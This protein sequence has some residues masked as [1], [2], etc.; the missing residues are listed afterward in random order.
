MNSNVTKLL[1]EQYSSLSTE[2]KSVFMR[3]KLKSFMKVS[4]AWE[5]KLRKKNNNPKH[6]FIQSDIYCGSQ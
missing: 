4:L 2:K 6:F 5:R 1:I 3:L